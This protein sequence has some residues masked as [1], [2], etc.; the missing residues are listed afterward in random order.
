VSEGRPQIAAIVLAA[1]L[2]RRMGANKLLATVD[3]VAMVRRVA[4]AAIGSHATPVVVVTGH[5]SEGVAL[6]LAGLD[7][8]LVVNPEY[9]EGLSTSLRAG[10]GALPASAE[11][12]VILLGDMPYITA[13][14]VDALIAAFRPGGIVVATSAGRRGNPVVWPRALFDAL[15]QVR[16]DAGGRAVVDANS[17][18][19]IPVELGAVAAADIDDPAALAAAGGRLP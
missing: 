1:G 2:S 9:A 14:A 17:A 4:Q 19:V 18:A 16:G 8:R 12:A 15:M 10:L 13:A 5:G 6:A 7:V 11:G 3:G